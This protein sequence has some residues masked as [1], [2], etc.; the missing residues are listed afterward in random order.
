MITVRELIQ[1]IRECESEP[2]TQSKMA[3]LADFYIIYDH[4][5]G[6]DREGVSYRYI[7]NYSSSPAPVEKII[8]EKGDTEFL[9]AA[10]GKSANGVL[11][12]LDELMEATKVLHPRMYD[13]VISRLKDL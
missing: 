2:H 10:N 9:Q 3:K 5:F 8:E 4:L 6:E 1:A 12:I 11:Q 7:D 13:Q